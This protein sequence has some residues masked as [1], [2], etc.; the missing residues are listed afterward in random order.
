MPTDGIEIEEKLV[1]IQQNKAYE[2]TTLIEKDFYLFIESLSV[3]ELIE[4]EKFLTEEFPEF[5]RKDEFSDAQIE[6]D[7][8]K[9]FT[10][11]RLR[12]AKEILDRSEPQEGISILL[13]EAP[14]S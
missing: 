1:E 11:A 5:T 4:F 3:N 13:D 10:S 14:N 8:S 6:T 2:P 7:F 12:R 9:L